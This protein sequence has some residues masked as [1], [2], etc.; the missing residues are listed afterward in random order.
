[1]V[2]TEHFPNDLLFIAYGFFKNFHVKPKSYL[3]IFE[4][5]KLKEIESLI[6]EYVKRLGD[7]K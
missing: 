6:E 4:F 3:E 5:S 7:M 2:K 1:M